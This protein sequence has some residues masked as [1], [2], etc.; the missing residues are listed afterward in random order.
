MFRIRFLRNILFLSLLVAGVF[1]LYNLF[2]LFPSYNSLL[3]HETESEAVRYVRYLSNSLGLAHQDLSAGKVPPGLQGKVNTL[4]GD[5]HVIKLRLFS[6]Q[7]E[8]LYSTVPA[9]IGTINKKDYFHQIVARGQVYSKVVR[10]DGV[11]AE[12][13]SYQQ[14]VV[15]TYVPIMTEGTFGGA[16]EVYHDITAS[17]SRLDTLTEH[18]VMTMAGLSGGLLL[19]IGL[20]LSKAKTTIEERQQVQQDLE[21][22]NA[23]LEQRVAQRTEE[24]SRTNQELIRENAERRR[25]ESALR[26]AFNDAQ[27]ATDRNEA[28]LGSVTDGLVVIDALQ[29]VVMMNRAA[30]LLLGVERERGQGRPLVGLLP[31]SAL[32]DQVLRHLTGGGD[33]EPFD[34]EMP[35]PQ[36]ATA[37]IYQIRSA[38][39]RS[40]EGTEQGMVLLFHDVTRERQIEKMKGEFLA[41]AAHEL[42]T[43]LA[44]VIG[45]AELLSGGEQDHFPAEKQRE[46]LEVI[47]E[48]GYALSRL[49]D[50]LLEI[51]RIESGQQMSLN[52]GL[53]NVAAVLASCLEQSRQQFHGHRFALELEGESLILPAD[54]G[55]IEQVLNNL[56]GNAV[57]YSPEGGQIAVRGG[58]HDDSY[59]V[60][61][62]DQGIGMSDEEV[63]KAFERFYRA[64][65]SHTAVSGMGLGL[66]IA[67][68]IV[69]AHGGRIWASSAKG[70]G[71]TVFFTLPLSEASSV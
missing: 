51:S 13:Q 32:Q 57:K 38:P 42:G 5:H 40:S 30:A 36:G 70:K 8:I 68:H 19:L 67:M 12:G 20:S 34:F 60:S 21:R 64:D 18:S 63:A 55:R 47:L 71:T 62:S 7:G 66:N 48:K 45:Y 6:P 33:V 9:E 27:E 23:E 58:L 1:P 46:F 39:L 4:Q 29:R 61:V 53:C 10:K 28:I 24:L 49:V 41:M 54:R 25:A 50:D 56:I 11:S 26:Q 31:T 69:S 35:T 16:V 65:A 22:L 43:P 3:I 2:F 15:E 44:S 59:L 14:D 37:S 17:L 52:I